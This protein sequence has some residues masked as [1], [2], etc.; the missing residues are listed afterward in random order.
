[1]SRFYNITFFSLLIFLFLIP[2][3]QTWTNVFLFI[4]IAGVLI[5]KDLYHSSI[6]GKICDEEKC[7]IFC[8]LL[9]LIWCFISLLWT[10]NF[11]CGLNLVGR[12]ISIIVLPLFISLARVCGNIKRYDLLLWSFIAGVFISSF[13]CVYLSYQDCWHETENG[14]K[15]YFDPYERNLSFWSLVSTGYNHFSYTYLAHFVHPAYFSLYFL[16]AICFFWDKLLNTK[17]ISSK[18]FYIF[19]IFY[20]ISFIYLLQSRS[21]LLCLIVL[22]PMYLFIF[23]L[24]KISRIKTVLI[25]LS[26]T[27]IVFIVGISHTRLSVVFDETTKTIEGLNKSNKQVEPENVRIILWK[28]AFSII[29]KNFFWGVGIG[30]VDSSME[31]KNIEIGLNV[32]S[33]GT[34]NQYIYAQLGMGVIGLLLL[35]SMFFFAFYYGIKN[36]YF[37]LIGFTIAVMIN[38]MFENML[39][40]S[41]GLM[42]IPWTQHL[43]LI[44]SNAKKCIK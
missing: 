12:Y 20:C 9:Y 29:K 10:E 22:F 14:L 32:V 28:N 31:R 4:F 39:T 27:I 30:D 1:M 41:A 35:M 38:L 7:N 44:M 17:K 21:A 24:K 42:F 6:L 5:N 13:V 26:L 8:S 16:L 3:N 15:F 43:L 37:P 40:R 36:K 19:T 34:H 25:G 23:L 2:F 11:E 18:F 33:L